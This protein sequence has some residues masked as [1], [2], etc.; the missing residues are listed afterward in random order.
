M[1]RRQFL[2]NVG[3]V[4]V[5]GPL[6]LNAEGPGVEA[7]IHVSPSGDD[8]NPATPVAPVRTLSRALQL[9]RK[10]KHETGFPALILLHGGV[11]ELSATLRLTSDDAGTAAC[12][13]RIEAFGDSETVLSGG[14]RLSLEWKPYRDGI[15]QA[16]V[17]P[18]TR[19]DQLFVNGQRQI[20]ARYPNFDKNACYFNGTAIDALSPER[21]RRWKHPEGAYVHGLQAS[22]WGSLHYRVTG[23]NVEG[24]LTME[25]G[26]QIDR[27]Q[28]M[29]KEFRF[30]EGIFEEL[31]A[32]GEWYLDE[33]SSTLYFYPPSGIDLKR[34]HVDIVRLVNLIEIG[35]KEAATAHGVRLRGLTFRHTQRTFMQTREQLLRSDW[36]IFRG[37]ALLIEN[38]EDISFEDCFFDQVGGN[39]VFVSGHARRVGFRTC[40]IEEAGSNG[41]CFVGRPGAVRNALL[42]YSQEA[43]LDQI[44]RKLGPKD[45]AYPRDCFVDDCLIA[46]TGRF[47]KQS[48]GVHISTSCEIRVTNCSIYGVPRAGI[49]IGDGTF[50]GHCVDGCDVFDTVLETSDHGA[51]NSW[52]RDRWWHLHGANED[53]LLTGSL[54]DLP[55]L[56]AVQPIVL[57]RTRWACAHGWDI[58][59]DDGSTNYRITENL[60][61]CG[62]IK[63]RE[64]FLRTALD[65][66]LVNNTFH[67][68]VWPA[69][70]GDVI[71]R[72]IVFAPYQPIRMRGWGQLIDLN[73]LQ[74]DGATATK[75]AEDL[76][77]LSGQDA[78]SLEGDALFL[79]PV[80]G[81]FSLRRSLQ[82]AVLTSWVYHIGNTEFGLRDCGCLP[83]L[84][85]S[86]S[87]SPRH[88]PRS[89]SL[90][91][92]TPCRGWELPFATL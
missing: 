64:G 83:R 33:G 43:S 87:G 37:G 80:G 55:T 29:H 26:W 60:C 57:T 90:G 69:H 6:A 41:I 14:S 84:R 88:R 25:G 1:N 38:A 15:Y 75:S 10:C 17:P 27:D 63:F 19:T 58:D 86:Q 24:F 70:T 51:F 59:L 66:V 61:L 28:P 32:P 67:P 16:S 50:G 65:N 44:D 23:R 11:H 35:S 49:N 72:N 91:D 47:E 53:D 9:S 77:R 79:D 40:R 7:E 3:A 85:I 76:Q 34:A 12:P 2:R 21:V 8:L 31:D 81:D 5:G 71:Q 42:G 62:G 22:L 36:R 56:D 48:A 92:V 20:L 89:P 54:L 13:L 30:V 4:A 39:A 45:D 68:H 82:R 46:R 74:R 73:F 52:G 18:G 78:L